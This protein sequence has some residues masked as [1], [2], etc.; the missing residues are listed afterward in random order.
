MVL[1]TTSSSRTLVVLVLYTSILT[2]F[3][4]LAFRSSFSRSFSS[5]WWTVMGGVKQVGV[6]VNSTYMFPCVSVCLWPTRSQWLV[7]QLLT[8]GQS[9]NLQ[10]FCCPATEWSQRRAAVPPFLQGNSAA[11]VK[12]DTSI[13]ITCGTFKYNCAIR[14]LFGKFIFLNIKM[15]WVWVFWA[16]KS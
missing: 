2:A 4:M 9:I 16:F 7:T 11:P 14:I 6:G 10:A 15:N 13:L 5:F 8:K 1:G 3:S 12:T